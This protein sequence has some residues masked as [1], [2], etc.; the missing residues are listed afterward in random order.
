[1]NHTLANLDTKNDFNPFGLRHPDATMQGTLPGISR[2][3]SLKW[4]REVEDEFKKGRAAGTGEGVGAAKMGEKAET[5]REGAK[6]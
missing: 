5:R 2:E 4:I 1:M 6:A 3:E